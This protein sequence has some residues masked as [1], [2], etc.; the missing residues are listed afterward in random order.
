MP[1]HSWSA[2]TSSTDNIVLCSTLLLAAGVF[3]AAP[4]PLRPDGHALHPH[5]QGEIVLDAFYDFACPDCK[6]AHPVVSRVLQHY[7]PK[8]IKFV[9]H[10]FP[11]PYHTYSFTSHGAARV[12]EKIGGNESFWKYVDL[13]YD[14]QYKFSNQMTEDMIYSEVLDIFAKFA[15]QVGVDYDQFM[16]NFKNTQL[17]DYAVRGSWK[18]GCDNGVSGTPTY[19]INGVESPAS[20][21]WTFEDWTK[22][23]DTFFKPGDSCPAN[24][25][26]CD[27]GTGTTYCCKS[28]EMCVMNVGCRC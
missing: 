12:V 9:L 27:P 26:F 23:L 3:A 4:V 14:Q 11:L 5:V 18:Y 22:Y 8:K 21:E 28:S 24:T 15:V 20:S 25:S 1:W 6:K 19:Y 10:D 13:L 16:L 7:G 2:P 17:S